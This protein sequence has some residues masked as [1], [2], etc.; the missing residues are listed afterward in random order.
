MFTGLVQ[1]TG[2]IVS[3]RRLET[4]IHIEIDAWRLAAD[5]AIAVGDS[6]AVNGVCLT[7][8]SVDE[9]RFGADVSLE[10]LSK[11]T[12][13]DT[14]RAVNLE[15]SLA[16]GD[17]LG[18]HLVSGHVDG[19]GTVV[20]FEPV[21]ESVELGI[22][23]PP[24]LARFLA[25]KGSV[26][27][28]GVSLTV[29]RVVDGAACGISINLIPHTVASTTFGELAVG[30]RVNLEIDLIARYVARMLEPAAGPR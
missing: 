11:T 20:R 30:A 17:K 24:A 6:I 15:S 5:H 14:C 12:G 25:P 9:G 10:T 4:G 18:G 28:D 7:A 21:G 19:V 23:A 26:A 27:V 1:A 22:E 2:A 8:T 16:L 13:L 3:V 29:N